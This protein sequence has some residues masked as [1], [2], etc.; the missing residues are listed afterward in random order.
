MPELYGNKFKYEL[1]AEISELN[2]EYQKEF[3][4][5][6]EAERSLEYARCKIIALEAK[7]EQ[8]QQLAQAIVAEAARDITS[9]I[10][11]IKQKRRQARW[12]AAA[13]EASK[14]QTH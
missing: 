13:E 14:E 7:I 11:E 10:I 4:A 12:D 9:E 1:R 6:L 3:R 8:M 2:L 5:R